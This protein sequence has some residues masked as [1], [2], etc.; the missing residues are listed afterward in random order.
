MAF[1]CTC[2]AAVLIRGLCNIKLEDKRGNRLSADRPQMEVVSQKNACQSRAHLGWK[3]LCSGSHWL[4]IK[5]A[6]CEL[7]V[8]LARKSQ[9]FRPL[10][11][12]LFSRART[13]SALQW[14]KQSFV[15]FLQ[16]CPKMHWST[17]ISK[18]SSR[19]MYSCSSG[20]ALMMLDAGFSRHQET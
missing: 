11:W 3:R 7:D 8:G 19:R 4:A 18:T 12:H 20:T 9:T 17:S 14:P 2:A 10:H 6:A 15:R 16:G 13:S 5:P 1:P